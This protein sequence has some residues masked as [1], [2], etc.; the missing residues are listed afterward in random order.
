LFM[1]AAAI[2]SH[3]VMQADIVLV[4][5]ERHLIE[6]AEQLILMVDSSKFHGASGNVVCGLDEADIVIT[7]SGITSEHR[8][9]LVTAGVRLMIV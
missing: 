5:S 9:M 7:D 2:G 1:G 4:A 6:R 3:G 8:H